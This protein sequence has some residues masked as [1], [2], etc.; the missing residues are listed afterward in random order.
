MRGGAPQ[1]GLPVRAR[2]ACA[3]VTGYA[4]VRL[5]VVALDPAGVAL[6]VA[7]LVVG[8]IADLRS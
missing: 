7:V 6:V 8:A 2:L 5:A 1:R 4:L 3:L